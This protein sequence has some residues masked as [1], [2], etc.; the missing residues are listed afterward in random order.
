MAI[1]AACALRSPTPRRLTVVAVATFL[2]MPFLFAI[3]VLREPWFDIDH[4]FVLLLPWAIQLY[5]ECM[6][7]ATGIAIYLATTAQH[8]GVMP[9]AI[10]RAAAI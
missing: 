7:V 2:A 4:Q 8:I 1:V 10:P 6:I 5:L 3:D 9:P